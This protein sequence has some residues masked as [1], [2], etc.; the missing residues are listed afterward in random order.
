M[1]RSRQVGPDGRTHGGD[2]RVSPA[3]HCVRVWLMN[4]RDPLP[5]CPAQGPH[6]PPSSW[7]GC[8]GATRLSFPFY[9]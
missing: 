8:G 7:R 6:T 3:H 4:T 5:T 9:R 2:W 1:G